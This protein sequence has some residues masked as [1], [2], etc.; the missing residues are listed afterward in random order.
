MERFAAVRLTL[1]VLL[2]AAVGAAVAFVAAIL[3]GVGSGVVVH[4]IAGVVLLVLVLGCLDAAYRIRRADHRPLGR[5]VVALLALLLAGATG[6][7][8]ALGAVGQALAGLPLLPIAILL[9]ALADAIRFTLAISPD[10]RVA[11]LTDYPA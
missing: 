3:T 10:G 4:E 9:F 11:P 6:A 8:L 1:L 7:G 2:G 5:V